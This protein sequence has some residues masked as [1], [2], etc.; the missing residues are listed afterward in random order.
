MNEFDDFRV[1]VEFPLYEV[2][3]YGIVR[4]R[5]SERLLKSSKDGTLLLR[6]DGEYHHK[7]INQ[8][9]KVAFPTE[10]KEK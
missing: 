10:Y 6:K 4:N 9:V 1:C 7:S 3:R 5:E 8:L 2:N